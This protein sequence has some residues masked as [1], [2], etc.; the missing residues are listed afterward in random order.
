MAKPIPLDQLPVYSKSNLPRSGRP[1][2]GGAAFLINKPPEWSSFGV[3]KVL[4]KCLD[5]R[6]VG[7]A[8]TLDPMA[9]GMLI[10]CSGRGTKTISQIQ[11]LAKT[12]EGDITFGFSTPT[13]DAKSEPDEKA[14]WRHIT[15]KMIENALNEHFVGTITQTPP[16]YSAIK[17]KGK[18][19]YKLARKGEKVEVK[20]R[21]VK[22]HHIDVLKFDPPVLTLRIKCSKGTYIRAVAHE[23]GIKLN[24][25]AHLSRL[26]RTAI[27][28]YHV[29][30]A[31]EVDELRSIFLDD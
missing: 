20:K 31:L 15:R 6:K 1:Y 13:Y 19:L 25:R 5:M 7:H 30:D 4:R 28:P 11:E 8:G 3:V 21:S 26:I 12:Y 10:L 2:K 29:D 24:S 16:M 17:H 18:P 22:I 27:G 9:T 14:D 23:L